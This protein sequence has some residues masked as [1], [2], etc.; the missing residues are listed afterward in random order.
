MLSIQIIQFQK[1]DLPIAI[2]LVGKFITS[3]I[4]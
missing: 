1:E 3:K 4:K 2:D